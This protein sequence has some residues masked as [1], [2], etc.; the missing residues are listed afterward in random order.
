MNRIPLIAL[1][2]ASTLFLACGDKDGDTGGTD[3]TDAT[4][5]DTDTDADTD[6]DTD[7]DGTDTDTDGTDTD[8]DTDDTATALS[9]TLS[10][11]AIDGATQT[12]AAEGLCVAA[13]NP[14]AAVTGGET[15]TM[16]SGTVGAAGSF[17][18]EGVD[19]T[20]SFGILISVFDCDDADSVLT[21]ATPVLPPVYAG[22]ETG[23]TISGLTAFSISAAYADGIDASL[24]AVGFADGSIWD[25]GGMMG[26]VWD[27][28][29]SPINGATVTGASTVFYQ[30]GDAADGLF[31]TGGGLNTSTV[32]TGGSIFLIPAAPI[33]GYSATASGYTFPTNT[34]GSSAGS[35]VFAPI[36][37][38]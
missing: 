32:A 1:F 28:T 27:N 25:I 23:D 3:T 5:T 15:V 7:T 20:P 17:S 14:D 37:A 12:P 38:N 35:I 4:D 29:Y 16:A 30:D 9:Y 10:G 21:T 8:T 24:A 11:T 34:L 36:I 13:L 18:I 2:G 19:D 31:S 22:V 6:A 33:G 26:G